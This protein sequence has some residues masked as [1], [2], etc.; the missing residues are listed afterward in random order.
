V[1]Y[2]V[3]VDFINEGKSYAPGTSLHIKP[4]RRT[5]AQH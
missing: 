1:L 3:E 5:S 2:I 4:A